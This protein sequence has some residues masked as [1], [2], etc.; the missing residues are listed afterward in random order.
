MI[1]TQDASVTPE[2]EDEI[3]ENDEELDQDSLEDLGLPMGSRGCDLEAVELGLPLRS[4]DRKEKRQGRI[5]APETR[6]VRGPGLGRTRV[7]I[8]KQRWAEVRRAGRQT[9]W[10]RAIEG[11]PV[12]GTR[13]GVGRQTLL[14]H[15]GDADDSV[16]VGNTEGPRMLG[17]AS[18][19][20]GLW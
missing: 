6:R 2:K 8:R 14:D 16:G 11:G 18:P 5:Q 13:M 12:C 7:T 1:R 17:G 9:N 10:A 20:G 19:R 15:S 3:I 4:P